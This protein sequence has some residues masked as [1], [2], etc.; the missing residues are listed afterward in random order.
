MNIIVGFGVTFMD[1]T[2][3]IHTIRVKYSLKSES[4]D[5]SLVYD[6]DNFFNV[7]HF[8]VVQK[9]IINPALSILLLLV[10]ILQSK[11]EI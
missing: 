2:G 5:F 7:Q 11:I 6:Q 3:F 10:V 9:Y 1:N 4:D 8:L